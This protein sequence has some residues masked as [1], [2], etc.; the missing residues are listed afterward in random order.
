LEPVSSRVARWII[1]RTKNPNLAN[2][3]GLRLEN[4]GIFYGHLEYFTNI[5]DILWPFGTSSVHLEHSFL[6]WY[7]VPRK[8]WQPWFQG[9]GYFPFWRLS[10]LLYVLLST[11]VKKQP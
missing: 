8:I 11:L 6:F 3:E 1:F 9:G 2:L 5:C 7:H 10:N 4:L